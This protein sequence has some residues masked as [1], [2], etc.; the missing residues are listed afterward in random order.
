MGRKI[1]FRRKGKT[2]AKNELPRRGPHFF[3]HSPFYVFSGNS[4]VSTMDS[5][6]RVYLL[7]L[8]EVYE[9]TMPDMNIRNI[10]L[11]TILTE[12]SGKCSI[13]CGKTGYRYIQLA[14]FVCP[15]EY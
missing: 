14:V 10:F 7:E 15:L 8:D 2:K 3:F 4:A 11:G 9:I 12:F 5:L 13:T 6:F 1:G